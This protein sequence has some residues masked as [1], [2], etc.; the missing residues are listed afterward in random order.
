DV[1]PEGLRAALEELAARTRELSGIRC[2]FAAVGAVEVP[3]ATTATH[4]LR[5]A[6]EAVNNALRHG[7]ARYILLS[8]CG[9]GDTLLLRIRDDG[10]GIPA[11][12]EESKG[13]G[14]G[15]SIMRNRA[16]VIGGSLTISR[17]EGCGTQVTCM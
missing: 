4:L 3:D 16:A 14:V 12:L 9:E 17:A 7:Q 8:L 6:Q 15:L 10:V 13:G 2:T 11:R 1:D 5:I